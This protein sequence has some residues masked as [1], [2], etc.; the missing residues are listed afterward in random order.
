MMCWMTPTNGTGSSLERALAWLVPEGNPAG[1]V[2]GAIAMGALLA[3][4]SGGRESYAELLGS[5]L[6]ALL[7]YWFAHSYAELL[8]RRLETGERLSM[9]GLSRALIR[10]W[11]IVRGTGLPLVTLAVCCVFGVA[12]ES[13]VVAA[14]WAT[15]ASLIGFELLAGLRAHVSRGQLLREGCAGLAMGLGIVALRAIVH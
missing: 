6:V 10:D 5:V 8:G 15:V 13:A 9:A 1:S 11:A 2:Y 4:E 3:A 12:R 7:L 14:L